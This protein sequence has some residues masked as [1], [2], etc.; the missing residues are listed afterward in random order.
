MVG[1]PIQYALPQ[2]MDLE[3]LRREL[4]RSFR[5]FD[6]G[7]RPTEPGVSGEFRLAHLAGG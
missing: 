4:E 2:E 3:M 6:V 5:F 1:H 7:R